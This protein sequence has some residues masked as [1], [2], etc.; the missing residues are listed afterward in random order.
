MGSAITLDLVSPSDS[1]QRSQR[2]HSCSSY[3]SKGAHAPWR[4]GAG[5]NATQANDEIIAHQ[6][7]YQQR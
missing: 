2:R 6:R 5:L 7:H 4:L 1:M 3:D